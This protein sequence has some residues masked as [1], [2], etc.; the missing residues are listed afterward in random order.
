[1]CL[2]SIKFATRTENFN[3]KFTSMMKKD[4]IISLPKSISFSSN[5]IYKRIARVLKIRT[6]L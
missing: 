5:A 3:E 6:K 4:L 2:Y 1:M